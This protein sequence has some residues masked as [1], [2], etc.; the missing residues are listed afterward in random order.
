MKLF[1]SFF[2]LF[3][4][5]MLTNGAISDNHQNSFGTKKEAKDLLERAVNLIKVDEVVGLTMMTVKSGGFIYKDLYPFCL[6]ENGILVSHP[7]NLGSS[8][9]EFTDIDG[10]EVGKIVMKTAKE[11]KISQISYKLGRYSLGKSESPD[12]YLEKPTIKKSVFYTRVGNYICMS[13]YYEN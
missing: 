3:C 7:Y 2:A 11:G 4:S 10:I 6:D 9:K 13:G 1:L 8:I 12:E 5:F